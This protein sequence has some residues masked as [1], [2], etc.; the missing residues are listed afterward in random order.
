[1]VSVIVDFAEDTYLSEGEFGPFIWNATAIAADS[2]G[3]IWITSTDEGSVYI[4]DEDGREVSFSP[5]T[6]GLT[7]QDSI[8]ILQEPCGVAVNHLNLVHVA[9]QKNTGQIF[10]FN[11][12]S[13]DPLPALPVDFPVGDI[14]FDEQNN[15][16]M[17][18]I[19]STRWHVFNKN[20][21]EVKGS[22]FGNDLHGNGLAVAPDGKEVYVASESE[23]KVQRW[24]GTCENNYA[25]YWQEDFL[26]AT[27]IGGGKV[28]TDG[29]GRIYVSHMPAGRVSIFDNRCII[30]AF[31]SGGTPPLRAPKGVSICPTGRVIYILETGAEGPC[32]II[33]WVKIAD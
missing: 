31:L 28:G 29:I 26:Q 11:A 23:N 1:M 22:P 16:F 20:W 10:R 17:L 13:G 27:R 8:V 9:D 4:L 5:I 18:E 3:K 24:L 25:R 21:Q 15:V 14:D 32:K 30:N 19:Q 2:T 33:K 7:L 12:L 6:S